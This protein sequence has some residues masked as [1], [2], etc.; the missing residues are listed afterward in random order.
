MRSGGIIV[1]NIKCIL[2]KNIQQE[3]LKRSLTQ[4]QLSVKAEVSLTAICSAERGTQNMTIDTVER[5]AN[6][7]EI[8]FSDLLQDK[9]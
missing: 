9:K 4:T 8:P 3:R 2:G 7:L 1:E 6:A 5:I